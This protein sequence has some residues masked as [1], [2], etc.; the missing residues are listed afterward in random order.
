MLKYQRTPNRSRRSGVFSTLVIDGH[1]KYFFMITAFILTLVCLEIGL[2][3]GAYFLHSKNPYYLFYG[4]KSKMADDDPEG[5]TA[6]FNGYFK[7]P[8][9]KVLSKYGMFQEPTPIRIN[10]LGFRG[11]DF[12]G[13]KPSGGFRVICL[14]GSSTFGFFN[15]DNFTYPAILHQLFS[16]S[17]N[18]NKV[19]VINAGI[20][21]AQSDNVLAMFKDE[22]LSFNPDVIT[23]YLGVNDA[24]FQLDTNFFQ[25]ILRWVHYHSAIYV[26][27]GR[28]IGSIGGPEL[29]SRWSIHRSISNRDYVAQQI[30]LHTQRY[31]KNIRELALLAQ[32]NN[33]KPIFIK[34]GIN[35]IRRPRANSTTRMTYQEILQSIQ[36]RLENNGWIDANETTHLVH[37]A[38]M[39]ILD[40][41]ACEE[42]IP[43]VNN[44]AILDEHPEYYASYVHLTEDGNKALAEALY[45]A[46][47]P[48]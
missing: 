39:E 13:N 12:T 38:L 32:R 22:V 28:L 30:E 44:I 15:R 43:I 47:N 45:L 17:I 18:N 7:F 31:E 4:I 14:G 29:Y 33:I 24:V 3:I 34:Q 6:V 48:N 25:T 37:A 46:L 1:K 26:A 23:L 19:E 8:P 10:S 5:H 27:L 21:E 41:I 11:A 35:L 20:P 2:R 36:R 16:E 40:K 9:T 42:S